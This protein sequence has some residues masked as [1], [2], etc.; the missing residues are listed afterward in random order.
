MKPYT[1]FQYLFPPRPEIK[2]PPHMIKN[3]EGKYI[4]QPKLNGSCGVLFT[5]GEEVVLMNRHHTQF[6][7]EIIN[8]EELKKL[9]RGN[10]W[11]VVVGELMNK[12]KKD[13]KGKVFNGFVIF[14]ILVL[15]GEYLT[16]VTFEERQNML[17]SLYNL[18]YFDNYISQIENKF[19][20][21]NNFTQN[22]TQSFEDITKTDMYEGFVFKKPTSSLD[23]GFVS[24]NNTGWQFKVR[25]PT[26]NYQY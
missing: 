5:N 8:K 26:K 23:T 18:T 4:A 6:E 21:V 1:E 20:R 25:K 9:H 15:N 22:L 3:H 16:G 19:Y 14:D 2:F 13:T 7:R 24:N 10:G 17:D 12:S 11:M